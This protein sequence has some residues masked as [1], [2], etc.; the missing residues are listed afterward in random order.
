VEQQQF[1][2]DINTATFESEAEKNAKIGEAKQTIAKLELDIAKETSDRQLEIQE[3][4]IKAREELLREGIEREKAILESAAQSIADAETNLTLESVKTRLGLY[5]KY[6]EDKQSLE[7][8]LTNQELVETQKRIDNAAKA[9]DQ[10]SKLKFN[11]PETEQ[12]RIE[13]IKGLEV[14]LY[15]D[16]LSLEQQLAE[17]KQENHEEQIARFDAFDQIALDAIA[18]EIELLNSGAATRSQ[19]VEFAIQE[20]EQ[21]AILLNTQKGILDSLLEQAIA[22]SD[23]IAAMDE[24]A[25]KQLT[26]NQ[27]LQAQGLTLAD[28]GRQYENNKQFQEDIQTLQISGNTTIADLEK[29]LQENRDKQYELRV[30]QINNEYD[31]SVSRLRLEEQRD[32]LEIRGELRRARA[33]EDERTRVET[34]DQL[35]TDLA[36]TNQL[37][38]DA[39]DQAAIARGTALDVLSQEK[40]GEAIQQATDRF[41]GAATGAASDIA[42]GLSR[43]GDSIS[44]GIGKASSSFA[45]AA[46]YAQKTFA[47]AANKYRVITRETISGVDAPAGV[48]SIVGDG[49]LALSTSEEILSQIRKAFKEQTRGSEY[50]LDYARQAVRAATKRDLNFNP[51][52][53]P[54]FVQAGRGAT[55]IQRQQEQWLEAL[56]KIG[57]DDVEALRDLASEIR[58]NAVTVASKIST[59]A[60]GTAADVRVGIPGRASGG[61]VAAFQPYIVGERGREL[62]IPSQPGTIVPNNRIAPRSYGTIAPRIGV[63]SDAD[64]QPQ[65]QSTRLSQSLKV[66]NLSALSAPLLP[67]SYSPQAIVQ[68]LSDLGNNASGASFTELIAE[69]QGLRRDIAQRPIPTIDSN[70]TFINEPDPLQSQ[71]ALLQGQLR[72]GR[73][74]V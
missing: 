45:E 26:L 31:L 3:E 4:S 69:I 7:E 6:G 63:R 20:N 15:N 21:A 38:Q 57:N 12:S 36:I 61:S 54:A 48:G 50:A 32:E 19:L 65:G 41:V 24:S 53:L 47:E 68:A 13:K 2:K 42:D 74:I 33:I 35:N 40:E 1:L 43:V 22:A 56:K 11:D 55:L 52:D 60:F 58:N 64:I 73:A 71:I 44:E 46:A 25:Q 72:A 34:I 39:Y 49:E 51:N 37:Y 67:A 14:A 8:S 28:I 16:R 30:K 66:P 17:Q 70:F 27:L 18:K 10:L 9:I 29:K 59:G 62:F 5:Q 23:R